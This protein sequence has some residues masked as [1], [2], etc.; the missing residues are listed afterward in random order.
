M[1]EKDRTLK[2][3]LWMYP[4]GTIGRDMIYALFNS[5][6]LTYILLTRQLDNAQLAAVTAI[7]IGARIFDAVNDPIMGFIIEKTRTRWGKF[8]PWLLAGI[9]STAGVIITIFN[10]TLQGWGFIALF[11]VI[12]FLY[13]ITYTM[14]DI[15][16]WGMIPSLSSS[17]DTRNQFTSR[18]VLFAGIGGTL[19]GMLIPMFTVGK[20]SLT[21][22]T[23]SSYGIISIIIAVLALLFICFTL[24]GVKESKEAMEV[25]KDVKKTST[26]D[27]LRTIVKN[28]PLLWIIIA[29]IFQQIGNS[30]AAGGIASTYIYFQ[31]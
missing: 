20:S 15:S 28:K 14:S 11:G 4:L 24:F 6:I 1:N 31:Y 19:A 10:T 29:F 21:G 16:Y 3:N 23:Q 27:I 5:F 25:K 8:K 9:L 13:S 12:Y 17:P 7:M 18:A 30:L 2:K 26:K 22:S